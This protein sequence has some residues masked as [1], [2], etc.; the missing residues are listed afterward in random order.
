[1]NRSKVVLLNNKVTI[2]DSEQGKGGGGEITRSIVQF[3]IIWITPTPPFQ[4]QGMTW[5][6]EEK[7]GEGIKCTEEEEVSMLH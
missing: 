3:D 2:S 7:E 5:E 1:M 4:L 6:E